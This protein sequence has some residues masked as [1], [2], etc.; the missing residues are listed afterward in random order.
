MAELIALGQN[1]GEHDAESCAELAVGGQAQARQCEG[2][3]RREL[4]GDAVALR[5]LHAHHEHRADRADEQCDCD[6]RA[7]GVA[8]D[9]A[10]QRDDQEIPQAGTRRTMRAGFPGAPDE[11][12]DRQRERKSHG[13]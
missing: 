11:K 9:G 5:M 12:S 10:E 3:D 1:R 13:G 7:A 6:R 4:G 8:R 2:R